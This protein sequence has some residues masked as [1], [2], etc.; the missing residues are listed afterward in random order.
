MFHF[1]VALSR[2]TARTFGRI[3]EPLARSYHSR[4]ESEQADVAVLSAV[5]RKI[6]IALGGGKASEGGMEE[7]PAENAQRSTLNFQHRRSNAVGSSANL[8]RQATLALQSQGLAKMRNEA[9]AEFDRVAGGKMRP[10]RAVKASELRVIFAQPTNQ[11]DQLSD[12]H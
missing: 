12:R 1:N 5:P 8:Y 7:T 9:F 10:L 3:I 11:E 4:C 2:S 6:Y